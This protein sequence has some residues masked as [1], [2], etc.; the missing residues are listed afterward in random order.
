MGMLS[1][2]RNKYVLFFLA[3]YLVALSVLY[4]DFHQPVNDTLVIFG[5]V[6]IGFSLIAWLL[7][8]NSSP[9]IAERP[10]FK[11]EWA[12]IVGLVL[13]FFF[14]VTYGTGWINQLIPSSIKETAWKND[15]VIA[16]KK[17]LVFVAVPFIIYKSI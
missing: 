12:I 6:G 3:I 2:F 17:L 5:C 4:F 11:H 14:Y 7:V 10:A 15:I 1:I 13:Y 8:K 16:V 9:V